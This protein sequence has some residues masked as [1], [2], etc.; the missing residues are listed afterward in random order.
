MQIEW[1]LQS[2]LDPFILSRMKDAADQCLLTE[3][4]ECPC[5]IS[6]CL[7]DDAFI[8]SINRCYRNIDAATDVLSFPS[9]SY[10]AGMTAGQC[11][12]LL[13]REY[14]AETR[15]CFLGDLFISVPHIRAQAAEYGHSELREAVY[16]TVHG[17]CHLLG[18]DHMNKSERAIMRSMEEKIMHA[19]NIPR[20]ENKMNDDEQLL[21]LAREAMKRSY[22]PYSSYPVGAA[23]Q[24]KD[25]RIFLGC[26][27]ENASFG[28]SNCAER[29]AVFKAVSEGATSFDV[30]AIAAKTKAWPCGA[31]RQVLNEFAPNL[32]ILVTWNDHVEEKMLSELLPE[33][34]GPKSMQS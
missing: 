5:M 2:K 28:L 23:L 24:S 8:A 32:R 22:S 7:C 14:D 19:I 27:V 12:K 4:V 26:N 16:L 11:A 3:K 33:G 20:A 25:G 1:N 31:C 21:S 18:Y 29:T 13:R 34:F 17:I 6:I 30:L 9:V 10:P 15:S